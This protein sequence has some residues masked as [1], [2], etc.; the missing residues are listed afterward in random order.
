MQHLISFPCCHIWVHVPHLQGLE[1]DPSDELSS[2]GHHAS[3]AT[4]HL[5]VLGSLPLGDAPETP[6]LALPGAPVNVQQSLMGGKARFRWGSKV[7]SL[8][9]DYVWLQVCHLVA[10]CMWL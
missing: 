8:R 10:C 6:S 5:S 3:A 7:V 2:G 9:I 1:H 4:P